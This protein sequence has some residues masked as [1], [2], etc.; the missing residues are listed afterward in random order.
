[1]NYS[2]PGSSV[3]G[4]SPDKN[5]GVDCHALLQGSKL[6]ALQADSLPSEPPGK[7]EITGVGSLPLLQRIFPTQ[8][9]DWG[10]LRCRWILYQLS[11]QGSPM[12]KGYQE[13]KAVHADKLSEAEQVPDEH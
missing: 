8:E 9:S 10:L 5:T 4:D 3:R 2:P 1:M 13:G 12:S 7:P 11:Y 6:S